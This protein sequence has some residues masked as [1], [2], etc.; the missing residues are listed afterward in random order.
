M[1]TQFRVM[2]SYENRYGEMVDELVRTFNNYNAAYA[3]ALRLKGLGHSVWIQ[4][5]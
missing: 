5:R 4:E 2:K 1:A 3:H